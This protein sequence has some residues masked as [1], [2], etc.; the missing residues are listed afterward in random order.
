MPAFFLEL[1][2]E[3]IPARMQAQA[4]RDLSRLLSEALAPIAPASIRIFHAPRRIAFAA[5]VAAGIPESRTV[6]RGPRRSA[7]EQALTGFLR[8]HAATREQLREEGEF[9]VLDRASP[10]IVAATLIARELPG[11]LRRFPWPK[12]MRWGGTSAFTW[13]RPLRRI[14]CLLDGNVVP[15]DLGDGDDDGHGLAAANLSEGHRFMSP[16]TFTVTGCEAWQR[17]SPRPACD[18]R[19][20]G[21]PRAGGRGRGAACR[22]PAA[23]GGRTTLALPTRSRAWWNGPWPCLAA[24]TPPTWTCR[25]R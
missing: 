22:R 3:E 11:L 14:V 4:A 23:F 25:R 12:S 1:F 2:S 6:E 15:F 18:R 10:G 13:V 9:W 16:G 21:A 5:E 24:S 7:P 19:S 8:K 17:R 20:G